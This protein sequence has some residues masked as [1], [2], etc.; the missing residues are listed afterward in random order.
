MELC[1]YKRQSQIKK[2]GLRNDDLHRNSNHDGEE[3]VPEKFVSLED[4]EA[5]VAM[6][7]SWRLN[8]VARQKNRVFC[9]G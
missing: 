9:V 8:R 5:A 6:A 4:Y 7:E 2:L 3:V 1:C